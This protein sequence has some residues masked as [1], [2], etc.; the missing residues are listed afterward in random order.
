MTNRIQ[1]LAAGLCVALAVGTGACSSGADEA[2]TKTETSASGGSGAS[3]G[4]SGSGSSGSTASGASTKPSTVPTATLP[5]TEP[6][7]T[8]S[9][10]QVCH[11]GME[12]SAPTTTAEAVTT[13]SAPTEPTAPETTL[14]V[15]NGA[16]EFC[17]KVTAASV[18]P[19]DDHGALADHW[20]SLGD[21]LPEP[22]ATD[23]RII[24]SAHQSAAESG[25]AYSEIAAA[26]DVVAAQVEYDG[27]YQTTC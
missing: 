2:Q 23:A 6:P 7:S 8:S 26:E 18:I 10:T 16:P 3:G 12:W 24:A 25:V 13:T 14:V 9:T 22:Y 19:A 17:S 15:Y 1:V 20:D 21:I 4:P 11:S 27:F 5:T